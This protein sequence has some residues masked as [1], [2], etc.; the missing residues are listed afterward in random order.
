MYGVPLVST[1]TGNTSDTRSHAPIS[2]SSL[3]LHMAALVPLPVQPWKL[4]QYEV[5][6]STRHPPVLSH[7]ILR[8][9]SALLLHWFKVHLAF[10]AM[11]ALGVLS[12]CS[13]VH[14]NAPVLL[15]YSGISFVCSNVHTKYA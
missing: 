6:C 2:N 3:A 1:R 8:G 13:W 5:V 4:I 14:R 12:A 10:P 15:R 9:L 7:L 11:I